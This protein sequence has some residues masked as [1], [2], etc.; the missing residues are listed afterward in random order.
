MGR[1]NK[2]KK[3]EA[4][5]YGAVALSGYIYQTLYAIVVSLKE[6]GWDRIKMEP[7]TAMGKVDIMLY[8]SDDGACDAVKITLSE[9]K[10]PY[11]KIQVKKRSG[12]VTPGEI[13]QWVEELKRDDGAEYYEVC[14]FGEEGFDRGSLPDNVTVK[15]NNFESVEDSV[16][17]AIAEYCLELK[18]KD[19]SLRDLEDAYARL[20]LMLMKNS[21]KKEPV[22]KTQIIDEL[23]NMLKYSA[24]NRAAV[25]KWTSERMFRE[26]PRYMRDITPDRLDRHGKRISR[27]PPVLKPEEFPAV[28]PEKSNEQFN[29]FDYLK[30][31]VRDERVSRH[32]FLSATSGGGKST[33]LYYLWREYLREDEKFIPIYVPLYEIKGS[34]KQYIVSH[35]LEYANVVDFIWLKDS[36]SQT[37]YHI[38]LF[39]DGYNEL[40]ANID[41]A[42]R[43]DIKEFFE[44]KNITVI[45][46]SREI[47]NPFGEEI[48]AFKMC[49]LKPAQITAFLGGHKE[50]LP[51]DNYEGMLTNPFMLE[52][53]I[54]AFGGRRIVSI[55]Q[56]SKEQ[57]LQKFIDKQMK[58]IEMTAEQKIFLDVVLPLAVMRLDEDFHKGDVIYADPKLYEDSTFDKAVQSVQQNIGKYRTLI[59]KYQ[60]KHSTRDYTAAVSEAG[61]ITGWLCDAGKALEIFSPDSEKGE[62]VIWDH[63]IYRDYYTARGYAIYAAFNQDAEDHV[64]NL[65]RQVNY[66]YPEPD[67]MKPK[68]D[69]V[70]R[71]YHVRK[72]QMFI[73][74]VDLH[75]KEHNYLNKLPLKKMKETAVYRR[76]TR[77]VAFIYE[78]LDDINM[79]AAAEL[80][81]QY[82]FDDMD[83]YQSDS[84]YDYE[85]KDRRYAD[86][87]YSLSGLAYNFSHKMIP[88][89]L[90]GYY[91]KRGQEVLNR[92]ETI[93]NKLEEINSEVLKDKTVRDDLLKYRGNLAANIYSRY[94]EDKNAVSIEKEE[95][96]EREKRETELEKARKL[97]KENLEERRKIRAEITEDID[98]RIAQSC[99]GIATSYYMLGEYPEAIKYNKRGIKE[100]AENADA[101][102]YRAYTNIIGAYA[103]M[104]AYTEDDIADMVKCLK[105]ALR[106]ANSGKIRNYYADIKRNLETIKSNMT[107]EQKKSRRKDLEIIDAGMAF[108]A[109]ESYN[110]GNKQ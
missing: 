101:L 51:K 84:K 29:L 23:E 55:D 40:A 81:M 5:S 76:L 48:T 37:P 77:D 6:S 36:F 91:Q 28:R 2:K 56:I 73:D 33:Y 10:K 99:L 88:K 14:L 42:V 26:N 63:E 104:P 50:Y 100:A 3:E 64:Y 82:Y 90:K 22:K 31:H 20:F 85:K 27:K 49:D 71:G 103:K 96:T 53:V 44:I 45:I 94:R 107:E 24:N 89:E 47:D 8:A 105:K 70:I 68:T 18:A 38:I 110:S 4:V 15:S 60:P 46:T 52:M 16:R 108:L 59:R 66:R 35:Y 7:V 109:G 69:K 93:F 61:D 32:I 57:V 25:I 19:W 80:S 12:Y 41:E 62:E 9:G 67:K 34:V 79:A 86:A 21:I 65:A 11:K 106:L 92:A 17:G 102:K 30:K 97:H 43:E 72:A 39:L 78:D 98:N 95:R 58:S 83:K 75:I 54:K 87:G 1:K 13:K 74:M